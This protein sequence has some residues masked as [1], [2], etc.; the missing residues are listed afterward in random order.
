MKPLPRCPKTG[1]LAY[2]TRLKALRAAIKRMSKCNVRLTAYSC[3]NCGD[4]HLTSQ[5]ERA[6]RLRRHARERRKRQP[7]V[8]RSKVRP[9]KPTPP[10]EPVV[11]ASERRKQIAEA[12][13]EANGRLRLALPDSLEYRRALGEVTQLQNAYVQLEADAA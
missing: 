4:W 9:L 3:P 8:P 2:R 6:Q 7:S 1:K 10:P 13:N 12:L 11:S 5:V